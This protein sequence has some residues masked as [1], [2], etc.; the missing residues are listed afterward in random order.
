MANLRQIQ[1]LEQRNALEPFLSIDRAEKKAARSIDTSTASML[2]P[3]GKKEAARRRIN[4]TE[5][6]RIE[7]K[8][9]EIMQKY[10]TPTNATMT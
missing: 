1:F 3:T 5:I 8:V 2:S 7:R 6:D 9:T 4:V 10:C